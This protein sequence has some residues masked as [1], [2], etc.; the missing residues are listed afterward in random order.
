LTMKQILLQEDWAGVMFQSIGL[1]VNDSMDL[2]IQDRILRAVS[3]LVEDVMWG[4]FPMHSLVDIFFVVVGIVD[5]L[6]VVVFGIDRH[7]DTHTIYGTLHCSGNDP[8][9][10]AV[11][12]LISRVL[13]SY[14]QKER[15]TVSL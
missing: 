4:C 12:I 6:F 8:E 14:V 5:L 15:S 11:D 13:K 1:T 7:N 3:K 10:A 9:N 2:S